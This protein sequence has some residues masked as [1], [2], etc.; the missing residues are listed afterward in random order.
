MSRFYTVVYVGTITAAGGD[1][2]LLEALPAANRPVRLRGLILSQVSEVG[3]AQEEGL[4]ISVLR[5]T[6][7]VTSGSGGSTVTPQPLEESDAAA[8]C[9][10]ECNNTTVATTSGST[11]TL[12]E[13]GWNNRQSPFDFWFPDERFAPHAKS[14]EALVVRLQTTLAD[15][16]TGVFTFVLEELG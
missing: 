12:Y 5:L 2:D 1:T 16:M 9:S 10:C 8:G 15:D 6:P 14:A 4:R 13:L 3:D 7:T 11:R